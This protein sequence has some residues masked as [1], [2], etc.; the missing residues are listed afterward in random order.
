LLGHSAAFCAKALAVASRAKPASTAE[1][2]RMVMEL[3]PVDKMLL[4]IVQHEKDST[5]GFF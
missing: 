4:V 5:R 3:S 1:R 2:R